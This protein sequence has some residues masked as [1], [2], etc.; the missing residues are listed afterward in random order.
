M[1]EVKSYLQLTG[2]KRSTKSFEEF[3]A[4]WDQQD[5]WIKI[6]FERVNR[7]EDKVR[8]LEGPKRRKAILNLLSKETKPHRSEWIRNRVYNFDYKDLDVLIAEEKVKAA[9][10]GKDTQFMYSFVDGEKKK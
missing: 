6:L 9:K 8:D 7:L 1:S 10:Y 2:N 4:E 3:I 5:R